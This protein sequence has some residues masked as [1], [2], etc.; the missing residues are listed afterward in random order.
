[1]DITKE[2]IEEKTMSGRL[3][4]TENKKGGDTTDTEKSEKSKSKK[5][6][7]HHWINLIK[8]I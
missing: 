6:L 1:M 7:N 4:T 3:K 8:K 5:N 2:I